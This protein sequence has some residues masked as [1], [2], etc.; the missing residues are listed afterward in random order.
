MTK[1]A[2]KTLSRRRAMYVIGGG[3][4]VAGGIAP[5]LGQ[6]ANKNNTTS[7]S[8]LWAKPAT[9]L[10]HAGMSQWQAMIGSSF[11]IVHEKGTATVRLQAVDAL[12]SSGIRPP[13]VTR[14]KAFAVK[15]AKPSK[16][17]PAGDR[18]YTVKQSTSL[19]QQILF[20]PVAAYL[21]AV[22]N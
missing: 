16:D 8:S 3:A 18:V 21:M 10:A 20:A 7:T 4:V 11:T 1:P 15:F 12:P 13:D 6:L 17:V 2:D 9:D 22:F 19:D 5:I 14:D